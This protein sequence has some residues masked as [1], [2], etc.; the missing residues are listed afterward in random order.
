MEYYKLELYIPVEYAEKMKKALAAVGAGQL[1]N[2][3]SCIWECAGVG[4]FRPL[5]GSEPFL[6]K[7]GKIE[8]VQENKLEMIVRGDRL[9][10]VISSIRSTHPYETPAFQFWP[11]Q[12]EKP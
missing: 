3:D 11:V 8:Q 12:L 10:A 6:G 2:Y 5:P 1:G 4:Q 9:D 7:A